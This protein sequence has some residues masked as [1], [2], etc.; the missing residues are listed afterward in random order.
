MQAE[1]HSQDQMLYLSCS[2]S[3][4]RHGE[5]KAFFVHGARLRV[6]LSD[7]EGEERG[8][9]VQLRH[10]HR[11]RDHPNYFGDHNVEE[12]EEIRSNK[13]EEGDEKQNLGGL[14][15]LEDECESGQ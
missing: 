7:A 5:G 1:Q 2:I 6:D 9:R 4:Q 15:K 3:T 10:L 13:E 11:V 12:E 14:L 8:M